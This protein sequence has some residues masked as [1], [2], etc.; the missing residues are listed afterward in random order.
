MEENTNAYRGF[1]GRRLRRRGLTWEDNIK[2][3]YSS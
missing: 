3:D 2:M 1:M